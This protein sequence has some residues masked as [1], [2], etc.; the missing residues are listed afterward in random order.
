MLKYS[1]NQVLLTA[2]GI[3]ALEADIDGEIQD[4]QLTIIATLL[5]SLRQAFLQTLSTQ[6]TMSL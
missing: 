2:E 3:A 4:K 5:G 6:L 1:T